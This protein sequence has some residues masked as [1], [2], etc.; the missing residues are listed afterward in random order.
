LEAQGRRNEAEAAYEAALKVN[1]DLVD[2]LLALGRLQRIRLACDEAVPLYER[3]EKIRPTFDA[4]Y[5]LGFCLAYLQEDAAAITHY[6]RAV[7]RDPTAAVAWQGLGSALVKT[8]HRTEGIA[9]LR[10]A[11]TIEPKM[12]DGWYMLGMAYQGAGDMV[13]AKEMFDKAEQTRAGGARP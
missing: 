6:E 3:A 8:G 5:G 4:A 11:V 9:A 1:P 2:A 13:R 10:K 12:S 7:K